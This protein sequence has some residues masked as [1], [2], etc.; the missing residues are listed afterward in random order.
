VSNKKFPDPEKALEQIHLFAL[1]SILTD[2]YKISAD[3]L[4]GTFDVGPAMS[5]ALML[6]SGEL[7]H[8]YKATITYEHGKFYDLVSLLHPFDISV[9]ELKQKVER[10]H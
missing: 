8:I 6:R 2:I 7:G 1:L 3:D 4:L 9:E 10:A 5:T